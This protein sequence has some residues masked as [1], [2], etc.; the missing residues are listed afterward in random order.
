MRAIYRAGLALLAAIAAGPAWAASGC[1]I[2]QLAALPVTMNGMGPMIDAK[3]NGAPVR[4]TH[5]P[6]RTV[7]ETA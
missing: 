5:R 6:C 7:P 3:I 2:G 4:P 1:T